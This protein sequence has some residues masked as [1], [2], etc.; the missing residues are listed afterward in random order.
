ML[1]PLAHFLLTLAGIGGAAAGRAL[2]MDETETLRSPEYSVKAAYLYNFAKFTEWPDTGA[3]SEAMTFC[4]AGAD[5]F[6][7]AFE[8]LEE[9]GFLGRPVV[10]RR[11]P[12]DLHG[13]RVLFVNEPDAVRRAEILLRAGNETIL[14]VGDQEGFIDAG[15]MIGFVIAD[16]RVQ[17]EA[18]QT[19][20]EQAGLTLGARMLELARRVKRQP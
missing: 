18:N 4:I 7:D 5:P 13:C 1:R 10:V 8:A 15:G 17:F 11:A 2:A 9:K 3:E 12:P 19:A 20:A 6:G 14:T 16:D